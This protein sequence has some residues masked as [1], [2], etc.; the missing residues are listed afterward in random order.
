MK[1]FQDRVPVENPTVLK[2]II[3]SNKDFTFTTDLL[4]GTYFL[5][6]PKQA[7]EIFY[8]QMLTKNLDV[9]LPAEGE[10]LLLSKKALHNI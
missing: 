5:V 6:K 9:F 7:K 3:L 2:K 10:G 1:L 4:I 8:I